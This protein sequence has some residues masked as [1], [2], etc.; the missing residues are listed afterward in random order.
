VVTKT[1]AQPSSPT[2]AIVRIA[3]PKADGAALGGSE[4]IPKHS[5]NLMTPS[6]NSHD[7]IPSTRN[8]KNPAIGQSADPE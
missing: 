6:L 5:I 1:P 8:G 4:P 3:G 7:A 2:E